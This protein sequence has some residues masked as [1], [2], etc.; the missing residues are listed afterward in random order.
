MRILSQEGELA[1][2][3]GEASRP[4]SLGQVLA[5]AGHAQPAPGQGGQKPLTPKASAKA[6]APSFSRRFL[7]A[8][9][10]F[11][12]SGLPW[13]LDFRWHSVRAAAR[14]WGRQEALVSNVPHQP[15]PGWMRDEE[16]PS[17]KPLS[18]AQQ[19]AGTRAVTSTSVSACPV[20]LWGLA[21]W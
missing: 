4:R 9:K 13:A 5:S 15:Q 2:S 20:S 3:E 14:I 18:W 6:V 21:P 8:T 17:S 10:T 19:F 12:A 11:S 7:P 1:A 16:R